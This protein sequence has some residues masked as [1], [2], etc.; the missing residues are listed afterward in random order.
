MIHA[1]RLS[2]A[3]ALAACLTGQDDRVK[4]DNEQ[5]RVLKVVDEVHRKSQLHEHPMNRVMIY[6][7]GGNLKVQYED[8]KIDDQ[9]LKAGQVRWSP[10]GGKHTS[11]NIGSTPLNIIEV[12]LKGKPAASTEALSPEHPLKVDP[13]HYKVE[14]ENSQVRVLRV[15]FGPKAKAPMHDHA[16]NR[17]V[18]YLTDQSF[19]VTTADG[20]TE[21]SQHKAGDVSWGGRAKHEEE[22][23]TDRPCELVVVELKA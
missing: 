13:K 7:T 9:K 20:K 10:G 5:V 2:L 15:K 17:V 18:V 16:L 1:A 6:L 12:E 8:G 22:N 4:I 19:K 21:Q 23:T 11:E 14:F 3:L